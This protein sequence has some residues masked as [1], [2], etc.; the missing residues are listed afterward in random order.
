MSNSTKRC[1]RGVVWAA[2][3]GVLSGLAAL[4]PAAF[5]GSAS[6]ADTATGRNYEQVMP[7]GK[8]YP[9]GAPS[10]QVAVASP[11]GNAVA[12]DSAGPMPGSSS[13]PQKNY[14]VARRTAGGWINTPAS[15]PQETGA[16][17]GL[18]VQ[19][20]SADLSRMMF[21]SAY[22]PL[23]PG[24]AVGVTNL[25]V[26]TLGTGAYT[27]LS[28]GAAAPVLS[29]L[30]AVGGASDDFT[31]VVFEALEPL[32]PGAPT[33]GVYEWVGGQLRNV[34]MYPGQNGTAAPLAVLGSGA[35]AFKRVTHA[36]S[37]DGR[38]IVFQDGVELYVRSDGTS[39]TPVSASQR[40]TPDPH[41]TNPLTRSPATFWAASADGGK[42]FFTSR[43]ERTDD[44]NTGDDGSGNPTDAGNDLYMYDV[45]S[46]VLSDLTVDT[47]PA[48][49]STGAAVQGVV[50]TSDDGDYVYFVALGNLATGATSGAYNLYVR[51]G[52]QTKYIGALDAA[53]SSAWGVIQ[54][55][56]GGNAGVTARVTP[57]G[58]HM[59]IQSAAR[60]TSYDN[61]DPSSAA[62]TSQVYRYAAD[63]A[64][65][66]C[67]SCRPDGTPPSGSARITPPAFETNT[68]RNLSDDGRRVFFDSA[69]DIVHD[70]TN[71]RTDVYEWADGAISLVSDGRSASDAQFQDASPSGDDVFFATAAQLV[72]ADTDG[73]YEL[74]DA[75]IGGGFPPQASPAAPCEGDGC[76]GAPTSPLSVPVAASVFF[77]G[78]GNET[79]DASAGARVTVTKPKAVTGTSATLKV[80]VPAKGSVTISGSGLGTAKKSLTKSGT[81][82]IKVSLTK[83]ARTSLSRHHQLKITARVAFKPATGSSS[84]ATVT[85]TFKQAKTS[86]KGRS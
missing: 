16:G 20:F 72:P 45:G 32:L 37:N 58:R 9:F 30:V 40:A 1:G 3:V 62:P 57:D 80:R 55:S 51:H 76:Q 41:S 81:V 60:L 74:Y 75:R 52:A 36:V 38:R 47:N 42:V 10:N 26:R 2:T 53:D 14:N 21:S 13:G 15:P 73:H 68:P 79:P 22:P 25:Y 56:L 77:S 49:A 50:G 78:P 5:V 85:L 64:T 67:V 7:E 19:G 18:V 39:T 28:L 29:Q 33:T 63:T 35:Q 6:A 27:L 48:D 4:G 43:E 31:H 86:R 23:V 69:D 83:Q 12:F 71:G 66:T 46:G 65:L 11:T 82:S 17:V 44:A 34:G 61:V 54:S 24:A 70:D 8:A 59:V 84:S